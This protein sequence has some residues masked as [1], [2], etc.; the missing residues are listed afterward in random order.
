MTNTALI[1]FLGYGWPVLVGWFAVSLGF[2][3]A[4]EGRHAQESKHA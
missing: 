4:Q 2:A 3:R 1:L